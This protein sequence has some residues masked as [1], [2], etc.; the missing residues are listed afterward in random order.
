MGGEY[1]KRKYATTEQ[2]CYLSAHFELSCFEEDFREKLM[3]YLPFSLILK[4][5]TRDLPVNAENVKLVMKR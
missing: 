3:R 4:V 5:Q 1:K 2:C